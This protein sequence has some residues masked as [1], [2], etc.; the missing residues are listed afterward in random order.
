MY[1]CATEFPD[2]SDRDAFAKQFHLA[3]R[4]E[5]EK[6]EEK[7]AAKT[8]R[9]L[10]EMAKECCAKGKGS[11]E[12]DTKNGDGYGVH[13]Y[14]S[15]KSDNNNRID[16]KLASALTSWCGCMCVWGAFTRARLPMCLCVYECM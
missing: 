3:N 9:T 11:K 1:W 10:K 16:G 14:D 8:I 7:S 2:F 13:D 5:N 12:V 4:G 6:V 15:D